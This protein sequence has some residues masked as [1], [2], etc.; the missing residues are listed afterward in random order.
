LARGGALIT[1]AFAVEH[2]LSA[3]N[4]TLLDIIG[5]PPP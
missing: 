2:E 4:F 5:V 3:A 1:M